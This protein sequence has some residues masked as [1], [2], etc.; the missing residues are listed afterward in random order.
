MTKACVRQ[1]STRKLLGVRKPKKVRKHPIDYLRS[2]ARRELQILCED[3]SDV[4][5]EDRD[6]YDETNGLHIDEE[7]FKQFCHKCG[8]DRDEERGRCMACKAKYI[9]F[10]K[11]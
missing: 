4:E 8:Y 7:W 2:K 11:K 1:T 5:Y 10:F 9:N 6:Y 3:D